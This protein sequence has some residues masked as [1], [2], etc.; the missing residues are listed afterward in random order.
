M[1]AHFLKILIILLGALC[2][3]ESAAVAAPQPVTEG[4]EYR[5]GDLPYKDS[6]VPD[7]SVAQQPEQ[8]QAID[9]P[10]NPPGRNGRDQVWYRVTL[11]AGDWQNPVLYI[12]SVDLKIGRAS[13][14]EIV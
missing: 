6:G 14:R 7:W 3:F 10:S 13:C 8:W 11:P 2:G 12:L 4:W 5:W 1:P 9:F